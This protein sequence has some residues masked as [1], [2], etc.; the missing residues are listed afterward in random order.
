MNVQDELITVAARIEVDQDELQEK[1]K[2]TTK[3]AH[4]LKEEIDRVEKA[5]GVLALRGEK[6]SEIYD[7]LNDLS[8][9]LRGQQ[10]ELREESKLYTKA[11]D[12][13][14]M[15]ANQLKAKLRDLTNQLNNTSKATNPTEWNKLNDEFITTQKRLKEVSAGTK[16]VNKVLEVFKGTFWGISADSALDAAWGAAKKVFTDTI[17]A[18]QEL[19]DEF[20]VTMTGMEFGYRKFTQMLATG[21]WS[22]FLTNI[23]E[24]IQAGREYQMMMDE[25]FELQNSQTIMETKIQNEIAKQQEIMDNVNLSNQQRIAAA[26]KIKNLYEK[27][28]EIRRTTAK[29]EMDAN[30][31]QFTH[32]TDL[33]D[34]EKEYIIDNYHYNR[35]TISAAT[36]MV[37]LQKELISLQEKAKDG[38]A[39]NFNAYQEGAY[40]GAKT[41]YS[42]QIS[43]LKSAI[44]KIRSEYAGATDELDYAAQIVTKYNM[45]NDEVISA[46]VQSYNKWLAVDG[47][48]DRMQRRALR[49]KNT[50]VKQ[51]GTD[52]VQAEKNLAAK[53]AKE[54]K[55]AYDNEI[56]A[57]QDAY[58]KQVLEAKTAYENMEIDHK[59]YAVR[60]ESAELEHIYR[61]IAINE[62]YGKS[63]DALYKQLA[64]K[65]IA[66]MKA[67]EAEMAKVI[68]QMDAD[69]QKQIQAEMQEFKRLSSKSKKMFP[70]VG[71]EGELNTELTD[72]QAMLDLKLITEQQYEEKR[73]EMIRQYEQQE[74]ALK[75]NKFAG[76]VQ[77]YQ[78]HF[79]AVADA[80]SSLQNAQMSLYDARM[81]EELAA[82]GDD[83][84]K[85][86]AIEKK[87]EEKKLALQKKYADVNMGIQIAQAIS[88]GAIAIARQYAD[89]PLVAAI[90]ASVLVAATT[91]AQIAV[92]VAQR[93]AIKNQS[94]G[95]GS[96]SSGATKQ[97]MLTSGFSDGGYTGDGGRLEPAGIVHRGEYVVP[98]PLMR[99]PLVQDMVHTIERM[100]LGTIGGGSSMPG[101]ANGGYVQNTSAT[102][103]AVLTEILALLYDLR[104]NPIHA[105]T[106]LSEY[107][108][109][110]EV[111]N[112]FKK[113]TSKRP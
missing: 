33:S 48:V 53:T 85:R 63:T 10:K 13:Q 68:A 16:E 23:R 79:N 112:R 40:V 60:V 45:T 70:G 67:E 44:A 35:K 1:L 12:L 24:A 91:G 29:Q 103:A 87:Y 72:L 4:K 56:M 101:Y 31:K 113:A 42:D 47:E 9:K 39:G 110:E 18:T 83:A 81:K 104:N 105:Y 65:Q 57:A 71:S 38:A 58:S 19:G 108:A 55:E 86:E 84:D 80:F 64:E 21:D 2:S 109:A 32:F 26:E 20:Q 25:V 27:I 52:A 73:L 17:N 75:A 74:K 99:T 22:H 7:E 102:E 5:M 3:E 61:K 100:R 36:E 111:S 49:Q 88:N 28:G 6:N 96:S 54:K 98:Q 94:V 34:K 66:T 78:N 82:A 92:A 77:Q 41:D 14:S 106:V 89:L 46:Y 62:L 51:I 76:E 107:Q 11:L 43:S 50:L 93:N 69:V 30:S 90:P 95:A 59:E 8:K 37:G 97:R 15:T